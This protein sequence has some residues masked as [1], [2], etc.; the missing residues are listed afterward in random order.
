MALVLLPL[1]HGT[2]KSQKGGLEG[3]YVETYYISDENDSTDMLSGQHLPVGSIT[4]RVFADLA[5]GYKMQMVYGSEGHPLS[6]KTSTSFFNNFRGGFGQGNYIS[7]VKLGEHTVA[8]D[9]WITVGAVSQHH[10]GIPKNI[11]PDSSVIGGKFNDGGSASIPQ[12]LL[13]NDD[14]AAG[15]PVSVKDGYVE[16]PA[17]QIVF[18]RLNAEPF[19]KRENDGVF[20]SDD[21]VYGVFEGV[22][23]VTDENM[24]IL[25]QFTTDGDFSFE[26]NLQLLASYGG[27]ERYV[28]VNPDGSE[29]THPELIYTTKSA[30]Q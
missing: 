28:A 26:L 11:D 5:P 6:I 20:Y 23:G 13:L 4:Y 22:E 12:G 14:P 19:V 25:G 30:N 10:H 24:V 16:K 15:A 2:V 1:F 8:L 3:V 27:V 21:S 29:F 9:S 7:R 17:P 18:Y